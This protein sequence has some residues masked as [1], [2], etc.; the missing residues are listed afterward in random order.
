MVAR[1]L[2]DLTSRRRKRRPPTK[3]RARRRETTSTL[4]DENFKHTHLW[5][6][7][8]AS[9]ARDADHR[10]R[11]LGHRLRP[12]GATAARSTYLRAPTPLLG[13]GDRSEVWVANADG[14]QRRAGDEE[15]RPG[16]RRGD[17]ARQ[18][19]A[20]CS[21]R[22]SNAH[23][24]T[25]YNGRLFVAPAGG[26][27]ARVVVGENE[28]LDVDR[29]VW[30]QDGKSI[31][32][33]ANLGVH[34]ELFVVPAAGGK[35]R[36]LTDGKHNIGAISAAG[37]TR[38]RSRSATRR[39]RGDVCHD[40]A[41]A[42]P[43]RSRSRTCST[44]SRATSSSDG[45]KRSRGRAPTASPSKASSPIRPTTRPDRNIRSR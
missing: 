27:A 44:T 40:G 28:P 26:G 17:L 8:V 37:A 16:D 18:R 1:R 29:A 5:K 32:F 30:S 35:P 6:V 39:A 34:E 19:A 36:Q 15:H 23:F 41:P 13:D 24:E 43:R 25:Y 42:T 9:K 4:Y 38:S 12:V 22:G 20:C 33:L 21:S 31:Y 11:L 14:S 10:R 3:R 2:G 7:T 45:R